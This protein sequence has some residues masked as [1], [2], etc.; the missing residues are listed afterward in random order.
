MSI[1]VLLLERSAYQRILFSNLLS[2]HKNIHTVLVARTVK[3][4]FER[5]IRINLG[6]GLLI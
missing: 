4:A 6:F 2:S 1:K 3:D 5:I